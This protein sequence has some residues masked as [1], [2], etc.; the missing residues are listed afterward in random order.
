MKNVYDIKKYFWSSSD[1]R[2]RTGWRLLLQLTVNIGG[3][4]L[5]SLCVVP[6]SFLNSWPR[7]AVEAVGYPVYLGITLLSVWLAGRF[8][9]RRAWC[10]FGLNLTHRIWWEDFGAGFGIGFV[11]IVLCVLTALMLGIIQLKLGF[12]SGISGVGFPIA[13]LLSVLSYGAVGFF[14]ELARA[15]QIRNLF[16]GLNGSRLGVWPAALMAVGGA[17][18][19]SAVMHSS[20]GMPAFILFVFISMAF[21][22]LFYLF[23]GRTALITGY[24]FAWDF[25]LATVFCIEALTE[26]DFTGLFTASFSNLVQMNVNGIQIGNYYPLVVMG[27][28][29]MLFQEF[30]WLALLGWVHWRRGGIRVRTE[31]ATRTA[32]FK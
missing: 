9:D 27:L 2:L 11:F 22:G 8:L 7:L 13:V 21:Q 4:L 18:L 31:M 30:A 32:I 14:E 28:A 5:F 15:Y 12:T 26:K 10:D 1:G 29:G 20:S 24:H 17:A 16:E 3:V 19:V 6:H 23:T 25:T